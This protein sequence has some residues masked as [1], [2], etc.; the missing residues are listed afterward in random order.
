M[1]TTIE[2]IDAQIDQIQTARYGKDVRDSLVT[3]LKS[4]N[5]DV[6]GATAD[7][8]TQEVQ[9]AVANEVKG[10]NTTNT[11]NSKVDTAV[12]NKLNA[13]TTTNTINSKVD[14][15]VTNK[16]NAQS[17]TNSID[18]K[19]AT[20]VNNL[21]ANE[22]TEQSIR[23]KVDAVLDEKVLAA[24]N[25]ANAA[26]NSAE[27]AST[28]AQ[29]ATTSAEAAAGSAEEANAAKTMAVELANNMSSTLSIATTARTNA[30]NAARAAEDAKT[31]AL[32][33]A[34]T[35]EDAKTNALEAASTAEDAKTTVKKA[36]SNIVAKTEEIK[37]YSEAIEYSRALYFASKNHRNIYRGKCIGDADEGLTSAQEDAIRNGTFDDIYIGD[38]W[39]DSFGGK[40]YVADIDYWLHRGTDS[41]HLIILHDGLV[42]SLSAFVGTMD[43]RGC[44]DLIANAS[45]SHP[46]QPNMTAVQTIS[47]DSFDSVSG[48]IAGRKTEASDIIGEALSETMVFGSRINGI[49]NDG[50]N[51][52]WTSASFRPQLA[53]FSL[54]P[55]FLTC[56]IKDSLEIANEAGT[57]FTHVWLQDYCSSSAYAA[58]DLNG[59]PCRAES[60][61]SSGYCMAYY[62]IGARSEEGETT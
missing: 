38:Y 13:A 47:W 48:K 60:S 5:K 40:N 19:V 22:T 62:I 8:I 32:E 24:S 4:L 39:I 29:D 15:A 26:S 20:A 27:A 56:Y 37:Q 59:N 58:I 1:A 14:T 10:T 41:H 28:S 9:T 30:Q 51:G 18:S 33:A 35:A 42:S 11:I 36:E 44:I 34:S 2:T 53:I 54:R 17:T 46:F 57:P 21:V 49:T 25:S 23:N 55:D 12:T 50:T 45:S 43:Q 7:K 16:L 6:S 3:A 52:E 31:N 61:L